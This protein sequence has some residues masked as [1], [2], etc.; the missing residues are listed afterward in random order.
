M[1]QPPNPKNIQPYARGPFYHGKNTSHTIPETTFNCHKGIQLEAKLTKWY[2]TTDMLI[3]LH[4]SEQ[5]MHPMFIK[6]S[7]GGDLFG[8]IAL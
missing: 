7:K 5:Q 6:V 2:E 8:Q 4:L 1:L 3:T